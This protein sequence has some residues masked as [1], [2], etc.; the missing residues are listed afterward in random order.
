MS[1]QRLREECE[2]VEVLAVLRELARRVSSPTVRGCLES[3]HDDIAHLFGA[4]AEAEPDD[5]VTDP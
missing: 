4:G 3:A 1:L 2:V 5:A